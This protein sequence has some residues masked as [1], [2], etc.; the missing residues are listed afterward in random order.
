MNSS[1]STIETTFA[2]SV[3]SL[4]KLGVGVGW[5][6]QSLAR[7]DLRRGDLISVSPKFGRIPIDIF[8]STRNDNHLASRVLSQLVEL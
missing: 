2:A 8:L 4:V 1:E 3:L 7:D 5:V 6:P